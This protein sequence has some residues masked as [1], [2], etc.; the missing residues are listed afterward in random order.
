[1]RFSPFNFSA[2][3]I[4]EAIAAETLNKVNSY[5]QGQRIAQTPKGQ[6]MARNFSE[7]GYTYPNVPFRMNAYQA[8]AGTGA[9]D[10]YA[11][12]TALKTQELL[13]KQNTY[14]LKPV[15]QVGPVKRAF[16]V[17]MLAL[18]SLFQP[19]SRGFKSAVVAAQA[20]GKS[21]P[22]T[23][24]LATLAGVPEIFWGDKGEGGGSVT[25]GILNAVL[26][27]KAG[28]KYREARDAYGPTELTRYIQEK[29]KGNPIN[30]GTGFMPKS[31]NLKETQEYLNAI[32]AGNSQQVAYNKAKA[33]YGR[34]ITNAFD[35]AEDRFKYTTRRGEK[36]N[37]SPGRIIA[38]TVTNPG[39][40]GYSVISGVI[41][42]VFRVAADPMNLA[43]M[44]GA[45]V[46][47]AMRGLLNANQK[48]ARSTAPVLKNV[49]FWKG[50][51]PGKTGKENRALYYGKTVDDVRNS[52]WGKD[53]AKA[54]ANL[55]GDEGLA[56][57]RDIKEF[58]RL[59]VSV[60][61]VLTEVDDPLH[62]WTVL[63]TVAKGGRLT[64][65]NYDDIFNVIKE[66]VPEGRKIELDRVRE[67]TK[68]NRNVGLDALPYK[69]TAYGEFFNYMNKVITGK[70]TDVAPFRKLA[71]L[72]AELKGVANYQTRGL[73]GLGS[74]LRMSLPKHVQRA[75]QLRPE[76]VVMW[77]QLDE[78]VKNID[79]M[80]KLAFVDPKTRGSIMREALGSA[81]QTQLD[82]VVNAANLEI[83]ESL[84]K[85]NPNLKFDIDEITRQQ[86]NFTAQMEELRSFFSGSAGSL[87]FNGTKIKKRYKSLIKDVKEYYERV[88]IKDFDETQLERYVFEAVPTMHLLSQASSTFSLLMDPQDI[89]RASKAHQQL[90]GPEESLLRAF[91]K[92]IGVIEDKNWVKQFKIPRRATAEAM[93]LK[94]QGF[95]DYYFNALQ[96]NF[97]KPLWMIRLALLLRV[98]PEEALR[99]AY[100]GKVNPF[101]SFFKRLSLTSNKYYE[102]FNIERADEVARIHNNLG[103]LVMTTQMKPDDI[104][105]MKNMIDVDDIKQLQAL[106]YNQAQKIAKHYLLETNYKGE[107]SEYMVNAAVNDFDIRNVKFAELTE[108]AFE[109]KK[110]NIKATATGAIKGYDG[111]T[112]NSM[113]EAIIKSGGFTT[114][115]DE[116]QF[117]DLGYRGPAEGDV[118]VSAYKDKEMVIGNLGT[119]EKEA[120][121]VNL[122]PAEYLDTQIDNLFFD[123]DTVALLGKDKHAVGVYTDK[124]GNIMIDVS[125]GL[126]GENAISNA[127]M[128]GIN[129]FQE[130]IYVAN[131]QLAIDSGFGK[132]LATG[133][134]EG[135]IFLHRVEVGKG[136]ASINYDSVINKPVL[137]ALFKSNFD[138]LKVT[139]DEVKGAARGMPGGS[140]FNNTP[141]YLS[142]LGE[143]AVTSAFKT[144]RKDLI[145]NM[146]IK[147]DKY[148][149]NGK[150]INPRYWEALWTEIEILATDPIAVRIA[151]IGLDETFSY[152][153]GDGKELLQDLVAR[154][155]NAEDKVYLRSD[156]AL[157]EYLESVQYRIARLVGAEH[158][159]INPQTGI[160]ISAEAARQVE[161]VNG[162]KVFPKFVSDLSSVNNSQILEMISNG[163]VYNR[164]DWVK[165]KQ[166]NQLLKGNSARLGGKS[167]K[168]KAN[169]AFYKEL[170]ELLTPEVDRAGLGPQ[171]L[172][173][174]F[175][176]TQRISESGT[177]IAGE[178][179]VAA[180]FFDDANYAGAN[181][182]QYRKILD[183]AYDVLLAK[184]SN[185]LNRDPLFR[186]TFYE[187]AIDLMAY[188]DDATR[189]EFLKGA[190]AWVDGNKLWDDLIEAA[191]QP[192]LENTVTSL[193]QAEDILK[194]KAME[195]VKTLLYSTSNRHVASDLFNKYIPFPEIWAEVFQSWGKLIQE[196]P[197]KFNKT[198]IAIDNGET[199][200]PWDSEN[201]FLEEDPT[202]GK[203]MFNYVDALNVLTF[204]IGGRALKA[205]AQRSAFGEDMEAEGVR[206]SIPGYAS[207]LNLIAQNGF[208]PG[209]GPLVTIPAN[210]IVERLP[211]PK[212]MQ[213][214]FL[215]SFGR[216]NPFDQWPAWMKKFFTSENTFSAERQQAFGTAVMDTYT[217]YVLAGKVDQTDQTSID[218]YMEKSF[219]KARSLFIFRGTTQFTLPTG[220][221]PRIE[222]QDKEGTWWATQVLKSK[223]D[224]LLL[225]NGY[226]YMQTDIDFEEKFGINPIP[227]T[228]SKSETMGKK[229]IKEHSYFWWNE[230]DRKK[231]LEP[232][233]LPNTGIYIQP[234]KIEDELYYP[235]FYDIETKNLNPRDYA[236]FMRQSQAIFE[237]EK[238]KKEIRETE[239]ER[240]WDD[241]YKEAKEKIQDEYGEDN[242]YNF[243][244]KQERATIETVMGE[245]ATWKD[246]ELTRNSP[247][248][249]FVV[250]YLQ[251]RDNVIDVLINN[252]RYSYTNSRGEKLSIRISGST[253]EARRLYGDS[254]DYL[255][256]QE[257]MRFIWEDIVAKSDG[258]NFAKLANEVLFYEIS[259]VNPRNMKD[260]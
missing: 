3:H 166:H 217:A 30:L 81:G 159:I 13:A 57:L 198:R 107:V 131:K 116:R 34:D 50:F 152:L 102:F 11:F 147:V 53:F 238:K 49:N 117:I 73:L 183:T 97:L 82:E 45:G 10:I 63:D 150:R 20:T 139:V 134:N 235:A 120:A 190:E 76:A 174:K 227:L 151:D 157:K 175:D 5:K 178:D 42:G 256:A 222:V 128:I 148:L 253:R 80:M 223:Y 203:M 196:N 26:G 145:E 236:Q 78:S 27:D 58:D 225:K 35:Q 212:I 204:G 47:T 193:K 77:T 213:D 14:N 133:D 194:Q 179:I 195:Q 167:I 6:E 91:G 51:L 218:K 259:P 200:K 115:L 65:Q 127:A 208:A 214:F 1:M 125:I 158:K 211:V 123:D 164:K 219:K 106:D 241:A 12:E 9:R 216:G 165:W 141:E 64:D 192:A 160:E 21:V 239:P 172:P 215:G 8:M 99:N 19:V 230:G 176:G 43:L 231:L 184:P 240:N 247:E 258:T 206:V 251:E 156:K 243:V 181:F 140:L 189:A 79:N 94:P 155:F 83:A 220:I 101:T 246:Y 197:Q 234:D 244:G 89:I 36:I 96:N 233:A 185:K 144:G 90:L 37:I 88:G 67:L 224:E 119:I 126:S 33:V 105:F 136:A 137:E 72:G 113:G 182:A 171:S 17:G 124:D 121:K 54:I 135:L 237:L 168:G 111:N 199:A 24:A 114:S 110:K 25:Q 154:S 48:A 44:Y 186:Y 55:Q 130:S 108:K 255:K 7:L 187:E 95:V 210:I 138:A 191:K 69:P 75:F 153:R 52:Q 249:P 180:G 56:F 104:E 85:Q 201:G 66:Y 161:F 146:F 177:M 228:Q 59:P 70:A 92:N 22:G 250:Q 257:L 39:S 71:A 209:F 248:Y 188:M 16:Q 202:T 122:T 254:N 109:T 93:S 229:P 2:S 242:I 100:G 86:A 87:A 74:Q 252:G 162:Y 38:A 118:F 4:S 169:E 32:R 142:S 112:Y 18:D 221:Q 40:T 226:D 205:V 103:E 143:Q 60:L 207:G 15:T 68:G 132:A 173:A 129:A 163:G 98:V 245:L 29:N 232:G 23:V 28:D 149:P 41:D 84:I 46:K 62:V 260:N 31:V 61:Q 170:I